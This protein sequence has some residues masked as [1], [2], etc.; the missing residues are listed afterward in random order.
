MRFSLSVSGT[1]AEVRAKI[2]QQA[3]AA[4]RDDADS[5][6]IAAAISDAIG[7]KLS[8]VGASESITVQSSFSLDITGTDAAMQ[9]LADR[10]V[11]TQSNPLAPA[12]MIPSPHADVVA[13]EGARQVPL[14]Q[15]IAGAQQ[16]SEFR[17]R[18]GATAS[19]ERE[20]R[21]RRAGATRVGPVAHEVMPRR[22]RR[23]HSRAAIPADSSPGDKRC[24]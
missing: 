15:G 11:A 6:T 2:Q 8:D 10:K 5:A 14:A 16:P 21:W 4:R 17:R 1:P 9:S 18:S 3:Q 19:S 20:C 22:E 12:P 7:R 23:R 24:A 13:P